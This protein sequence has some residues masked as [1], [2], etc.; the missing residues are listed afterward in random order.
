MRQQLFRRLTYGINVLIAIFLASGLVVMANWLA[1]KYPLRHDYIQSQ[2]LYKLSGKTEKILT[3]LNQDIEFFAFFNPYDPDNELYPKIKRLLR[4]YEAVSPHVKVTMVDPVQ[5]T[6][7]TRKLIREYV[8]EPDTVVIRYG[9]RTRVLTEM[10]MADF[11]FR[12]NEYTGAQIKKLKELKAE[13]AFTSAIISLIDPTPVLARF[14]VKHG[15]KSVFGYGNDGMTEARRLMEKDNVTAQPIELISLTEIPASTCDVLVVAGPTRPFMPEEINVIRR[16]LNKGGRALF[17]LDPEI[18][19]GLEPLL[20]EYNTEVTDTIVFDPVTQSPSASPLQLIVALYA[21]HSITESLKTYTIFLIAR[22]VIVKDKANDVNKGTGLAFTSY[23]G[24]ADTDTDATSWQFNQNEDIDGPVSIA[25]A[26][27]NEKSGMR[28]VTVG[29]SDFVSNREV[30]NG[31]N[32]D[33]FLNSINW[34]IDREE[35]ISIS[36]KTLIERRRLQLNPLAQ[37]IVLFGPIVV[38]PL[39]SILVGITVY[40]FRRRH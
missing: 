4:E 35:L 17:L 24:W 1:N 28:I 3:S 9:D 2:D 26:I 6:P 21:P 36:P 19:T 8:S 20:S 22:A 16:Y 32:R 14:T 23:D 31:T 7:E 40:L 10:K 25:V 33:F 5:Q 29:D 18:E 39:F 15:E 13:Q 38:I 27:E 30:M 34:L 37:K 11:D 12:L